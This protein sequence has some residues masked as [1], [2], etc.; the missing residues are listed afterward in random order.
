MACWKLAN[1]TRRNGLLRVGSVTLRRAAISIIT[2]AAHS[3]R[4]TRRTEK[5]VL[6]I[7]WESASDWCAAHTGKQL[8]NWTWVAI[9]NLETR[10]VRFAREMEMEVDRCIRCQSEIITFVRTRFNFRH[11]RPPLIRFSLSSLLFLF[12]SPLSLQVSLREIWAIVMKLSFLLF[13][14]S[15]SLTVENYAFCNVQYFYSYSLSTIL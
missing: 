10:A 1:W 5:S 9:Y 4:K 13:E 2:C 7:R 8:G 3:E 11:S 15:H 12:L 6:L 14:S